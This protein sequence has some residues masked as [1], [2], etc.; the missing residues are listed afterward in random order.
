VG[1]CVLQGVPVRVE[2]VNDEWLLW[3]VPLPHIGGLPRQYFGLSL[4]VDARAC[5]AV[6]QR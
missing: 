3:W 6:A 1:S 2:R 4:A 5:A